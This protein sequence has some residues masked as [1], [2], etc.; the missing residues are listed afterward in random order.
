LIDTAT[1][2][3]L[4]LERR[5]F[6]VLVL[7]TTAL[8]LWMIRG[9]LLPIF[10]AG[11]FAVL[12][13]PLSDRLTRRFGGRSSLA[14]L[15]TLLVVLLLVLVPFGLIIGAVA[16]QALVLYQRILAGDVDVQRPVAFFEQALPR[17][18]EALTLYGIETDRLRATLES[19]AVF[20][21]Q[22]VA[23]HALAFG[24]NAVLVTIL[25]LLMFY[26]LFFFLRD[27]E[28]IVSGV[29]RAIPMGEA[30]E[31]LF[32]ARIAS[33]S[34]AT[35]RGTLVVAAVQGALGGIVFA[36]V[37]IEAAVLWAVMMGILSL[38]PA[39]GPALIWGPAAVIFFATGAIWQGVFL[40]VSGTLVIGLVD[41]F[42]RPLIIGRETSMPDYLILIATLGGLTMFGL[43]GLVAG[44]MIAAL[45]LVLWEMFAEEYGTLEPIPPQPAPVPLGTSQPPST[46]APETLRPEASHP[47]PSSLQPSAPKPSP[48][49][50]SDPER[51]EI[52]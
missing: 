34:R 31:K 28:R 24:Q 10:W 39:V 4:D 21:T 3:R 29:A 33:V 9:F 6:V 17:V 13:Q 8:F 46:L 35:V 1:V 49:R 48:S 30:R 26:L 37:G 41:N 2:R 40:I 43:A 7:G 36:I 14:A 38:L 51:E 47:E 15:T 25:F 20:A 45:L 52:D 23:A 27:G 32:L 50:P 16:Q 22:Y 11:V 18:T 5:I 12:F 42:L 19:A 44:P